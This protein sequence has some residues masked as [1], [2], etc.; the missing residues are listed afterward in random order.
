[1]GLFQAGKDFT[2]T[3]ICLIRVMFVN[4]LKTYR[5]LKKR[6]HVMGRLML[7]TLLVLNVS[8]CNKKENPANEVEENDTIPAAEATFFGLNTS[9]YKKYL[10]LKQGND[11]IPIVAGPGV[12]DSALHR[13]QKIC[14][15][16]VATLPT[17]SLATLR[18]QRIYIAIFGNNEY[19]NALPGWPAG[20]DATRYGGGFGPTATYR[21]CGIH[22]GDIMKNAFDRYNTENIVVHEFSH[23]I[24]NFA[25]EKIDPMFRDKVQQLLTTAKAAGKWGNTYAGS[26]AEEYWAEGVQTYFEVNAAGPAGGDGVHNNINTRAELQAYDPD[27]YA[28]IEQ[29]YGG[30]LL[31]S[32]NW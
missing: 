14:A 4:E 8:S 3:A 17:H 26:N 16:L 19:P 28:L 5:M 1:L 6:F 15:I 29:V 25:L 32:G 27:I 18:T 10:S 24:K 13:A 30:A 22:E 11:S 2:F 23:A 31:P 20:V 12:A 9:Y 7:I 21:V